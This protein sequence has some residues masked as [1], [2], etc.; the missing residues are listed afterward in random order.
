[1]L[2]FFNSSWLWTLLF[3]LGGSR[4]PLDSVTPLDSRRRWLG[5]FTLVVFVLVFVPNPLNIIQP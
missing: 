2:S 3:F 5:W 1:M 4:A